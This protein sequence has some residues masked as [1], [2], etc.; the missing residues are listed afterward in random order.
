VEGFCWASSAYFEALYDVDRSTVKRWLAALVKHGFIVVVVD[1]P[2]RRIYLAEAAPAQVATGA[3]LSH[4]PAQKC[5]TYRR[6]IEP[7]SITLS[8]TANTTGT[9]N[10]VG[11]VADARAATAV[12]GADAS[13]ERAEGAASPLSVDALKAQDVDAVVAVT[14]D[15]GSRKRFRQLRDLSESAGCAD[16]WRHALDALKAAQRASTRPVER[17]G[18]YFCSVLVSD[19]N[20]RGVAVPVATPSERRTVRD[21][22]RSSLAAASPG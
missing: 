10:V 20:A 8:N 22:I 1:G 13:Q 16:S 15:G 17:P 18:A 5:A 7:Q 9:L 6:K 14:G 19:L 2:Q 21:A 3:K 11:G 4:L 12:R